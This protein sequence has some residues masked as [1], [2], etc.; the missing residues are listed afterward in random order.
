MIGPSHNGQPSDLRFE[1]ELSLNRL[2]PRLDAAWVEA[3][4]CR[5]DIHRF[6]T[7]LPQVWPRL[8]SLFYQLYGSRYDFFYH[9]EQIL[10]TAA[11]CWADRPQPLKKLD[12]QR[13]HEPA[14]FQSEKLVGGALYVDLFSENLGKL[15]QTIPYFKN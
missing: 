6:E 7:R 4:P 2:R 9:L 13:I 5:E 8:F 14:W 12:E 15:R 10:V 1:A 11:R 3:A